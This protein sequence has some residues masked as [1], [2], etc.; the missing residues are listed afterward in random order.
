[1]NRRAHLSYVLAV[2]IG[3]GFAALVHHATGALPWATGS[4]LLD[5]GTALVVGSSAAVIL[6]A[7]LD[8]TWEPRWLLDAEPDEPVEEDGS[9]ERPAWSTREL[10]RELSPHT[11]WTRRD[12]PGPVDGLQ[13]RFVTSRRRERAR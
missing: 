5:A 1:V 2:P 9:G 12:E 4:V 13:I 7:L 3:F 8:P 10:H 11:A 6:R